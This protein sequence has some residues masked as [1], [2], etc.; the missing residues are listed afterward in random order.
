[1][2]QGPCWENQLASPDD[3][4]ILADDEKPLTGEWRF[5]CSGWQCEPGKGKFEGDVGGWVVWLSDP[6]KDPTVGDAKDKFEVF[7]SQTGDWHCD[8]WI[9][10]F[11]YEERAILIGG[12]S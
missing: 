12:E 10:G 8:I 4:P 6:V 3:T 1:M 11:S 2:V 9:D 7:V 5:K